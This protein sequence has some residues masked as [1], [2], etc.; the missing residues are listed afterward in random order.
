MKFYPL[1]SSCLTSTLRL[2]ARLWQPKQ[3]NA[4]GLSKQRLKTYSMFSDR[5]YNEL[6]VIHCHDFLVGF[7]SIFGISCLLKAI[8]SDSVWLP[9]RYFNFLQC[10]HAADMAVVYKSIWSLFTIPQDFKASKSVVILH[11]YPLVVQS[12][13]N[14]SK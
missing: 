13:S 12:W 6:H 7:C 14:T 10:S 2:W 4:H 11:F 1:L 9:L 3:H 8:P 5:N